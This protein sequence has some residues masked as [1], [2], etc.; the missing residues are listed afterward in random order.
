MSGSISSFSLCVETLRRLFRKTSFAVSST[1]KMRCFVRAEPKMM[2][3]SVKGAIRSR[4]AS[5]M[6]FMTFVSLSGT[7]SHL[8]TTTT[9]LFWFFCMIWKMLRSCD[10][11]PLVA[12]IMRMQTSLFSMLRIERITL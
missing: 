9:M 7:R 12:S 8:L 1:L 4:I 2:G 10:S 6:V 11:M 3:K 5:S